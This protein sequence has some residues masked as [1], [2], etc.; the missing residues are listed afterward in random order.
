MQNDNGKVLGHVNVLLIENS[1]PSFLCG[2]HHE[3]WKYIVLKPR[4]TLLSCLHIIVVKY[5]IRLKK[6]SR[7]WNTT[8]IHLQ[9]LIS[10]RKLRNVPGVF[11]QLW[12]YITMLNELELRSAA[13]GQRKWNTLSWRQNCKKY[14]AMQFFRLLSLPKEK[15]SAYDLSNCYIPSKQYFEEMRFFKEVHFP[16]KASTSTKRVVVICKLVVAFELVKCFFFW[17]R[18]LFVTVGL[19]LRKYVLS[20]ICIVL[21]SAMFLSASLIMVTFLQAEA[22]FFK[23]W[24]LTVT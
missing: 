17:G 5:H 9:G 1:Y 8:L 12:K 10:I 20:A 24:I 14:Q 6:R 22:V 3:K 2:K 15:L 7:L 16:H 18:N 23:D 11:K 13:V 21:Y 19:I 4:D